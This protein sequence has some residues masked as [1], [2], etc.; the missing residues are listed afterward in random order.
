MLTKK[1]KNTN[2]T[3]R[4]KLQENVLPVCFL[5]AHIAPS[6]LVKIQNIYAIA[7]RNVKKKKN[8]GKQNET[9]QKIKTLFAQFFAIQ[10][11][12]YERE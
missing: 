5:S 9:K 12:P 4:T 11:I 1:T 2:K 6:R 10:P 3:K 7:I 8:K